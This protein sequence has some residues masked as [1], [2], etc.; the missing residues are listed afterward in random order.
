M[1]TEH[2]QGCQVA[3]P[4]Q[5]VELAWKLAC[6]MR[7]EGRFGTV[8][9]LGAGDARFSG[10]VQA[11]DS[12]IGLEI[13]KTKVQGLALPKHARIK[14]TDALKWSGKDFDLC[15]G[16]PPYIRHHKLDPKWRA[17]VL[18]QIEKE[19]G[20]SL[21][22]TANLFVMFLMQALLRTQENGLVLQVVPYEWVTRPSA[23]ELREFINKNKWNVT[24]L[25]FNTDIFPQVLTTASI[26]IIDK[27]TRNGIWSFGEIG[28]DG[29]VS[30]RAHSSG[31]NKAV[32]T[33]EER[34]GDLYGLRG[35]SPGGQEFF[36]LTESERLHYSLKKRIDVTPCV[37]SLR[38]FPVDESELNVANFQKYY[39]E[40]GKRCWLIRSDKDVISSQLRLYLDSVGDKWKK[41]S[42]C[43][44]R[45]IWSRYRPHPVPAL[46]LSSGFVGKG[47]KVIINTVKAI[48]AGA[49]YGIISLG[50][51]RPES[52][53]EKL[54]KIDFQQQV[55]SH[56]NNLKK[57]E[58]GQLNSVLTELNS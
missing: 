29:T 33:Y 28:S 46:L 40:A 23:K 13:D 18:A 52:I 14:I 30:M 5:I 47:P 56:A 31:S 43:T 20:V 15:I 12:Y 53:A 17:A 39:V 7:K 45:E 27:S 38:E 4:H 16:N 1:K 37:T 9:D 26:T 50:A 41:Y 2:L 8:I 57:L 55:V 21:K 58:V 10:A 22:R 48:A 6:G 11:Y 54:R 35:L 32:L 51:R 49:V 19:S 36:V 3:T 42:T 25:R 34:Q 24:V 44:N